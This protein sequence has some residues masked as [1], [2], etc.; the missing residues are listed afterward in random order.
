MIC[1]LNHRQHKENSCNFK[2]FRGINFS[3]AANVAWSLI[4][5]EKK[6]TKEERRKKTANLRT[7]NN[8]G[9]LICSDAF[10]RSAT[11]RIM[12]GRLFF[13]HPGISHDI[14]PPFP[15]LLYKNTRTTRTRFAW[16]KA[17][18]VIAAP[19][20]NLQ[21]SASTASSYGATSATECHNSRRFRQ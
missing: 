20:E 4:I 12:P 18:V 15:F 10:S 9:G 8:V 5:D 16:C 6:R 21:P 3:F 17:R 14:S 2:I 11:F 13:I 19:S 7:K 1:Q